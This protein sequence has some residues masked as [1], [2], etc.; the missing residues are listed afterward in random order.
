MGSEGSEEQP[1]DRLPS[2]LR[3]RNGNLWKEVKKKR[4]IERGKERGRK[5][6]AGKLREMG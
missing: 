6:Q 1:S 4:G 2:S 3:S 5:R